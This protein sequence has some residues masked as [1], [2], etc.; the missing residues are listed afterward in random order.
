[1]TTA[2]NSR[3]LPSPSMPALAELMKTGSRAEHTAAEEATFIRELLEGR[4]NREGY[5]DY[6]SQLF[7]IYEALES[8]GEALSDDPCA[9]AVLREELLR[10]PAIRDDLRHWGL[11]EP[12]MPNAATLA[13]VD[14]I[15]THGAGWG[16]AY[17]AHHYT[18]Y[19]GDLSG[20]Q[21]IGR[22]LARTYD[23][24]DGRG[25]AF[26]TFPAIPKVKV[27][28]DDYRLALNSLK[29]TDA[30]KLRVLDEVKTAFRL[31]SALFASFDDRLDEYTSDFPR[32]AG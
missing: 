7:Y 2:T 18:R 5:A 9:S 12:L 19:L 15:R 28:K 17:V 23:L 1:M 3:A 26:Y 8:V 30:E 24:V 4:I 20:G 25:V 27:F 13:Y 16:G 29:F 10:L 32:I 6:L 11:S 14:R 22:I 31:N 21:A